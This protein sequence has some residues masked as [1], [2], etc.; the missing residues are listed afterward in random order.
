MD[1]MHLRP[2]LR[3]NA[4]VTYLQASDQGL[5]SKAFL[6][7]NSE[8]VKPRFLTE[9]GP[10]LLGQL[11]QEGLIDGLFV[12]TSPRL[13]G[14]QSGDERKS[15]V[16]GV[17]LSGR[18]LKLSSVRRHESHLYNAFQHEISYVMAS[19]FEFRYTGVPSTTLVHSKV[20]Y[21]SGLPLPDLVP[22]C[23]L[24]Y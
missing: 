23:R 20:Q 11:L 9:G 19:P 17:N 16:E 21:Q 4:F 14:R 5:V 2:P 24:M 15:L 6:L 1:R 18:S 22:P 12:T 3:R 7:G 10:S 13:F 8:G